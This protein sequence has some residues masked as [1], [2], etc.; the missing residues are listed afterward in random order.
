[1]FGGVITRPFGQDAGKQLSQVS[2]INYNLSYRTARVDAARDKRELNVG[3]IVGDPDVD[4]EDKHDGSEDQG[5]TSGTV[6]IDD[7]SKS[8]SSIQ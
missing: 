4:H 3:V 1:M 2:I 7:D 8:R 5:L 6:T